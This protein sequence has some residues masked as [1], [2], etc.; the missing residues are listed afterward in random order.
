MGTDKFKGLI[1]EIEGQLKETTGKV[2][3]NKE[4]EVKGKVQKAAGK[5]QATYS[6]LKN[7]MEGNS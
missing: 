4:L 5:T 1:N 6:D 7:K 2:I 3:G